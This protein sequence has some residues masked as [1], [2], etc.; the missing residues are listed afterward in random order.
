LAQFSR[1]NFPD[2]L[3]QRLLLLKNIV[4]GIKR[5]SRS[6]V[7]YLNRK[8]QCEVKVLPESFPYIVAM[9]FVGYE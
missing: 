6:P 8:N 3:N 4:F 2:I 7:K 9:M 5:I 1:G